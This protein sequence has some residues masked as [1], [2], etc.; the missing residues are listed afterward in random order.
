MIIAAPVFDAGRPMS[1]NSRAREGSILARGETYS[2]QVIPSE[3]ATGDLKP[4]PAVSR[5]QTPRTVKTTRTSSP[6]PASVV[7]NKR[8]PSNRIP[9]NRVPSNSQYG[10]TASFAV[11]QWASRGSCTRARSDW[12]SRGI[13]ANS[14]GDGSH[15]RTGAHGRSSSLRVLLKWLLRKPALLRTLRRTTEKHTIV[16]QVVS[17]STEKSSSDSETPLTAQGWTAKR[18]AQ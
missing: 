9:A 16:S 11:G 10:Q 8:A 18:S 7:T 14:F 4:T 13:G 5:R 1:C 17:E 6:R 15:G 2:E 3:D 12:Q